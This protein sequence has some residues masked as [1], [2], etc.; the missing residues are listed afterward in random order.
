[1]ETMNTIKI[2]ATSQNVQTSITAIKK[3]AEEKGYQIIGEFKKEGLISGLLGSKLTFESKSQEKVLRNYLTKFDK[4]PGMAT[5]NRLLHF[6]YKKV[7]KLDK[8]PYVEYSEKELKIKSARKAWRK[9]LAETE[10]LMKVYKEEK[11]DFY[12]KS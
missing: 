1:M 3:Y 5:A 6:L 10:A 9:S 4:K 11:K 7:Y 12:K 8:A 2:E